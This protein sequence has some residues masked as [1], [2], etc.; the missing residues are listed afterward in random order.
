MKI[1]SLEI[2]VTLINKFMTIKSEL[3]LFFPK[4]SKI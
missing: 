1:I 2:K 3:S 4:T